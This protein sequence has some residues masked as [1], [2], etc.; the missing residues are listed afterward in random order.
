MKDIGIE[1]SNYVEENSSI[2]LEF[3]GVAFDYEKGDIYLIFIGYDVDG[4]FIEV[5]MHQKDFSIGMGEIGAGLR[6]GDKVRL[7]VLGIN[8]YTNEEIYINNE[9]ELINLIEYLACF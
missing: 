5:N 6:C 8:D 7:G 3:D 2:D 9:G 1:Y 4:K